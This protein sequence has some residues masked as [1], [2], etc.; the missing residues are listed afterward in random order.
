MTLSVYAHN[1]LNQRKQNDAWTN[2]FDLIP[3]GSHVLDIG[4]STGNFGKELIKKKKCTVVGVDIFEEDLKVAKKHLTNVYRRNIEVDSI[5]DLGTFDVILMADV[6]E[7]LIDPISALKKLKNQ[8]KKDGLF[9]FSVPNMANI[10]VRLELLAGRFTYTSYGLLDQTH[11]HYYDR[12]QLETV[13]KNAGFSVETYDNTV[14]DIPKDVQIKQMRSLGL[15]PNEDFFKH[16]SHEDA[17]T[18]QFI[19][20]AKVSKMKHSTVKIGAPYDFMSK[21]FDSLSSEVSKYKDQ[22]NKNHSE[23]KQLKTELAAVRQELNDIKASRGWKALEKAHSVI[24]KI[25]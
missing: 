15:E 20:I 11:L 1:S 5:A 7:H 12:I 23:A 10:G 22:V 14:R 25:K 4:C 2:L 17:I 8:L 9:V 21:Q 16:T 24:A 19:G 18:F 6:I 13:L 3:E